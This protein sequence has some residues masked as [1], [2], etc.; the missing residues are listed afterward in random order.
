MTRVIRNLF[1]CLTAVVTWFHRQFNNLEIPGSNH[2]EVINLG[3]CDQWRLIGSDGSPYFG[4]QRY[5]WQQS[6]MQITVS[7]A[8]FFRKSLIPPVCDG[9]FSRHIYFPGP[10]NASYYACLRARK[11]TLVACMNNCHVY[12]SGYFLNLKLKRF[13]FHLQ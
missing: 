6:G 4:T 2:I 12:N 8:V 9:T 13:N 7:V 1:L 5:K 10:H 3:R 11:Y